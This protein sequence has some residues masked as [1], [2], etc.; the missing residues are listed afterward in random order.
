MAGANFETFT[1]EPMRQ[2]NQDME[3]IPVWLIPPP[4]AGEIAGQGR[5]PR[6][7][8]RALAELIA[9]FR[10]VYPEE[11]DQLRLTPLQHG[12]ETIIERLGMAR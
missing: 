9:G 6:E 7:E 2:V 11:W 5:N 3:R 4:G 1:H 8:A 12:L 10:T